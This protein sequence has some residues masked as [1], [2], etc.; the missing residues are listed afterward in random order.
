VRFE[1]FDVRA[2]HFGE[3]GIGNVDELAGP[4]E[5]V[6]GSFQCGCNFDDGSEPLVFLTERRELAGVADCGRIGQFP[7]DF[8]GPRERLGETLAKTQVVVPYF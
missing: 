3:L 8:C 7:F 1:P 6:F 5:L 2:G 4:R